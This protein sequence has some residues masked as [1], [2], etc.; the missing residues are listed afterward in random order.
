V[1]IVSQNK[2]ETICSEVGSV[3][4]REVVIIRRAGENCES[5]QASLQLYFAA[6]E[7]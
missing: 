3:E 7:F 2:Q 5:K 6:V 4:A 1:K